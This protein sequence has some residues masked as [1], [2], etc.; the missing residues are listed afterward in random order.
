MNP[1]FKALL[2]AEIEAHIRR[3]KAEGTV[4]MSY[5]CLKQCVRPPAGGPSGTNAP[6]VYNEIFGEC[7]RA[8]RIATRFVQG[9][10]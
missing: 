2:T 10:R 4:S 3:E 8:S 1:D 9:G 7:V 6:W 5:A